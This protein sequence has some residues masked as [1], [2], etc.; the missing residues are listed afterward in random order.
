MSEP[1]YALTGIGNAM[2]D[3]LA[4][5]DED[6]IK[7]LNMT[8]GIMQLI[9]E[10][11]AVELYVAMNPQ[12]ETGGGSAANTMA[13]FASFGGKGAFIGKVADDKIGEI[14]TKDLRELG[15]VYKGIHGY[16]RVYKGI[17]G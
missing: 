4:Q 5:V 8:K 2:V 14:F 12:A 17:Y 1:K 11:R 13:G 10:A 16:T 7:E 6:F 9:D 15:L 3:V